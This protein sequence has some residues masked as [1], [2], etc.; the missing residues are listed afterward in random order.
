MGGPFRFQSLIGRLQ[1]M[2]DLEKVVDRVV[3]QSLIGRLQT[4]AVLA[5]RMDID[6][7]FQSLIGR[8]QTRNAR[9]EH[10]HPENVS[11]PHR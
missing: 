10:L 2:S 8:L 3:F 1:T 4:L 5:S 9:Q 6:A 7:R 11:I